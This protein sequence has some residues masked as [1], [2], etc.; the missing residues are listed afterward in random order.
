MSLRMKILAAILA[1]AVA[2]ALAVG[3]P[4]YLGAERL[5]SQAA[6]SELDAYSGKLEDALRAEVDRGLALAAQTAAQPWIGAAM[7][8]GD[9][10]VI[11][12]EM[13]PGF[14][15][16]KAEHGVVQVQFHL[17]PATSFLRLHSLEEFGDDLSS[18]RATVVTANREKRAVSG[19]ERGRGGLGVRAVVPVEAE[20]VHVGTVEFGMSF[21]APFFE[22]LA[23]A[24]TAEAEFYL[25]PADNVATFDAS[26][27]E[28][29]R[30]AS[31]I[32]APPLL[33]ATTLARVRSGETVAG[34]F[35]VGGRAMMGRV[36]PIRD[37][38]GNVSGAAHLLTSLEGFAATSAE[39]RR[40]ALIGA[41]LAFAAALAMG[42]MF[43]HWIGTRLA[44]LGARMGGVAAGDLDA[45]I[46]GAD[47]SDEIGGMAKALEVFR[48]NAAEVAA[49]KFEQE[50]MEEGARA[51]RAQ[52][53]RQL[54]QQIGAVVEAA[55]AGDLS[56]RVACDFDEPDLNALG[57]AVNALA[58]T[59]AGAIGAVRTVLSA[60]A[61]GDLSQRMN[62]THRGEFAAL[63]TDVNA[64]AEALTTLLGGISGAVA[65]LTGTADAMAREAH[66]LAD[67]ASSQAASLEQT[68]ATM[69]QMS[70]T[71]S[72]NAQS[73]E[74]ASGG[75]RSVAQASDRSR[76][77]IEGAVAQMRDIAQSAERIASITDA[78]E[79]IAM[80]T[81]LLALNAAVEAARAG[82]AG[83]G[84]AVVASEVRALA[85]RASEAAAEINTLTGESRDNVAKGVASVEGA[86]TTLTEMADQIGD[87]ERLIGEISSASREQA[88]GVGEISSTI[89]G[90]D[91][92]TQE[93]AR[94]A[95][96]TEGVVKALQQEV[97]RLQALSANFSASRGRKAA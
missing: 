6:E 1:A 75:A 52:M 73:A 56:R 13:G 7:R 94:I 40:A 43:S 53:L 20:G 64:T 95:D 67:R 47:R 37:Y 54:G 71:V 23:R 88:L 2:A 93:N 36:E 51:A 39:V 61:S 9:R 90:L 21:G 84:F 69:E 91:Q 85:R 63:Q 14:P 58:D 77:A 78:I 35:D 66:D 11:A 89:S 70:A 82:E 25:F 26:D 72:S 29:S 28:Q 3:A 34:R 81:N 97:A 16:M 30:M 65:A 10:A 80:Q 49:L 62:G 50:R 44:A 92:M 41:G 74:Q 27:A 8:D 33:D 86:R 42:L 60:L 55:A 46:E 18:F 38:A 57:G 76:S 19:L 79:S 5:V 31:T 68:S 83:K 4:L 22:N 96:Q 87:L 24:A 45:P 17:P 48:A 12:R 32:S 15:E 59:V